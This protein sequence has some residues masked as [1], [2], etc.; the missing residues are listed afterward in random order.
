ML[1]IIRPFLLFCLVYIPIFAVPIETFY[2][3][4][5][6]EEPVLIELIESPAFQRLKHIHQYGVAYY[7]THHEEYTRYEHSLGVFYLLREK[8]CS[9]EEQIAGLLHDVSHTIFS[10]VGDWVF[11]RQNFESDYQTLTHSDFLY[12]SGL[13]RILNKHG[14]TV[15][16]VL[17]KQELFPALE[18]PLPTLCA[19]RIDY[20]LQGAFY[21]GF[22]THEEAIRMFHEIKFIDGEWISD[23][24]DLLKKLVRFSIFMSQ[25]CWGSGTEYMLSMWLAEAI[26]RGLDIG[27]ISMDDIRFGFDQEIW[28]RLLI[29]VDP[30]I[31][32]NMEMILNRSDHLSIVSKE[33]ADFLITTKFRGIN[34]LVEINGERVRLTTTDPIL[35]EEFQIAKD[36]MAN[37]WGIKIIC[38]S[39]LSR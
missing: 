19:D 12:R 1:S 36:R 13:D 39:T 17:P 25:D 18:Q 8:E 16:Q 35:A 32:M 9:L 6:V 38:P 33:N 34:P 22:I 31:Q 7:I 28:D 15:E 20:N 26:L 21:Q 4:V 27:A 11:N 23:D 30:L 3:T 10:H 14:Y 37:G 2:G 29:L 5:N 24:H